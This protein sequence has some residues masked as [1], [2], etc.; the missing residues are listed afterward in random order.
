V[1]DVFPAPS[2]PL[3]G[4][5]ICPTPS[6][7]SQ[8]T[9]ALGVH[10]DRDMT[11]SSDHRHPALGHARPDL[12]VVT[13]AGGIGLAVARRLG[14]GRPIVLADRDVA[15]LRHSAALLRHDGHQVHEVPTD[16]AEPAEV[17]HL[18]ATV[19]QLGVPRVIVHTA[20]VSPVQAPPTRVAAV[21]VVG[22]ALMI[23]AFA[24]VV[25]P[26]AVMV[27]IASIAGALTPLPAHDENLLATTPTR[28]LA[29][30]TLLDPKH[31]DA[32]RAYGVAK[33]ANQLRVQAAAVPWGRKGA[34]IVSVSPGIVAT[35]MASAEFESPSGSVMRQMIEASA[36]QRI[37]T[38]EDIAAV[39]DFLASPSAAFL[40]GID[41]IADGGTVAAMRT[42][43]ASLEDLVSVG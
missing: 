30:L 10:Y 41:V 13:G 38:P 12:V 8:P 1:F 40:T 23:D 34:R 25:E 28:D 37:G 17:A 4:R 26:G 18:A 11:T 42:V 14:A 32:A 16:V 7:D 21:D 22:T 3:P 2:P 9:E 36:L 5:D 19:Q 27:C 24:E 15:H 39:V 43:G 6:G 35:P 29:R 33:R 20:G 31:L